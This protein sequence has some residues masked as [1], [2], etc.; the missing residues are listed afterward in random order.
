MNITYVIIFIKNHEVSIRPKLFKKLSD[1]WTIVIG[2]GKSK[3]KQL[4]LS[5]RTPNATF[6]LLL[7]FLLFFLL[8][9]IIYF[10]D[11]TF[12]RIHITFSIAPVK[13]KI[14]VLLFIFTY[15]K[16]LYLNVLLR[17]CYKKRFKF[18]KK[19]HAIDFSVKFQA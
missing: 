7:L 18:H 16:Y 1:W 10:S 14:S 12:L 4:G 8:L 13:I 3:P 2:K 11:Y 17:N 6:F 15:T 19:T 5:K 9:K